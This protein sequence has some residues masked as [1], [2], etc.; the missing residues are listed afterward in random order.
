[1]IKYRFVRVTIR[2]TIWLISIYLVFQI[3]FFVGGRLSIKST[4]YEKGAIQIP[5]FFEIIDKDLIHT[6][7]AFDSDYSFNVRIRVSNTAMERLSNQIETSRFFNAQ[8]GW[9]LAEPIYDSLELYQLGGFWVEQENGYRFHQA[10]D[11]GMEPT[12]I[13]VNKTER[14]INLDLTHL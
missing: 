6:P 1:M 11:D 3:V 5:Y 7:N 9:N 8:G 10:R 13:T 14:I 2:I 12:I 4:I